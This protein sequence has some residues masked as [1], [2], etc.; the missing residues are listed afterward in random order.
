[1]KIR[2]IKR[3]NYYSMGGKSYYP[4]GLIV[5]G[6]KHSDGLLIEHFYCYGQSEIIPIEYFQVIS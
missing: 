4:R 3:W 5:T 2:L 6:K 1:M